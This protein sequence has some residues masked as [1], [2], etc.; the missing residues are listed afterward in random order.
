MEIVEDW[1]GEILDFWFGELTPA[2]WFS[3]GKELDERIRDRFSDL[4]LQ[5]SQETPQVAMTDPEAALAA[6]IALDQFPRNMFRGTPEAFATDH[7]ALALAR[8]A[9]QRGFD[10]GMTPEQ[11]QFLAMPLMHSETLDDQHRCVEIFRDIGNEDALKYAL[12]HR[13][14]VERFGRFPHRNR[15]LGRDSSEA[16]TAFLQGH[17][18][19]GQ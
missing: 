11:R 7:K 5:L 12:E 17:K 19:Y 18:G 4:Y 14:I 2:D 16:E 9:L 8:N 10:Q 15:A 6:I 1:A 13:D 3:G